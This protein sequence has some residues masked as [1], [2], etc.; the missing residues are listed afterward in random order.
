M[1]TVSS[2]A[3]HR[4]IFSRQT[5]AIVFIILQICFQRAHCFQDFNVNAVVLYQLSYKDPYVESRPI[6]RVHIF[7]RGTTETWNKVDFNCENTREMLKA[8]K[9]LPAEI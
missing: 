7:T 2:E 9:I 1:K 5:E 3:K 4:S 6:Y 8:L